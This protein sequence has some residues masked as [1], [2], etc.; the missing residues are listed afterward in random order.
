MTFDPHKP[1]DDLP[2]LPPQG[3][4]ETRPILKL[5]IKAHTALAEL[6]QAGQLI[7]NQTMLI[8]IIPLLEAQGS[9]EI[10]NIVTT[11]DRLFKFAYDDGIAD[12][13]TKEAL[14]Y[15][16]ALYDGIQAIKARPLTANTALT[17]CQTIKN[18]QMDIRTG[19]VALKNSTGHTIYTPPASPNAIKELL[20]N[21]ENFLHNDD[22]LDPL[23]STIVEI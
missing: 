16:T 20:A 11:T 17:I 19:T 7:P 22:D 8:N 5:C 12:H 10:E 4:L 1:Y 6:R 3:E 2:R 9:S 21:W 23:I 14:R 18:T 15:R 13:A